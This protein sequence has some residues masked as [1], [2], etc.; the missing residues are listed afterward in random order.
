VEPTDGESCKPCH[1]LRDINGSYSIYRNLI[2]A[3]RMG[4][5]LTAS[6]PELIPDVKEARV[7]DHPWF[8]GAMRNKYPASPILGSRQVSANFPIWSFSCPN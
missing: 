1:R 8:V 7:A 2:L 3:D 5:I 4:R 6:T